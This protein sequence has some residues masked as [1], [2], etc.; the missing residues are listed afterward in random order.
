M[1]DRE[2]TEDFPE[3]AEPY[4]RVAAKL[5]DA[6][7]AFILAQVAPPLGMLL[8]LVYLLAGD[9]MHGGQ[10]FGKRLLGLRVVHP[11]SGLP[12]T[13]RQSVYR[14]ADLAVLYLLVHLPL[15]GTILAIVLGVFVIAVELHA[16]FRDPKGLRIGDLLAETEVVGLQPGPVTQPPEPD[17]TSP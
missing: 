7:L 2:Q 12:A 13:V 14:N 1:I 8:G 15:L 3:P 17:S 10:S 11:D 6:L 5:I 16:I 4:A 9:A